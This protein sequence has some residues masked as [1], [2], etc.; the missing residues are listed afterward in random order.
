[1][2]LAVPGEIISIN[3]GD[4]QM[5]SGKVKFGG[6][7]LEVSLALV[8]EAKIGDYVIVHAGF[9]LGIVDQ[10]EAGKVFEYLAEMERLGED[11]KQ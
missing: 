5:P 8:P 7:I 1:M 3:D 10:E 6:A 2:C 11:Q 9:A 4:T